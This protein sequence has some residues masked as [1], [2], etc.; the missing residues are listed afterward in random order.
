M[1]HADVVLELADRLLA[2]LHAGRELVVATVVGVDGSAPRTLGTSMAWD[3]ERVIGSIA[4]GCVEGAV[5]DVAD[6]VLDDG[7]TRVIEFGVP[8]DGAAGELALEA[9]LSCGGALTLHLA[10][11]RPADA[12]LAALERASAGGS[13]R[14][15]L[16]EA[17][18]AVDECD[19]LFVDERVPLARLIIVGAMEFSVAL[20]AAAQPLGYA[21]TV[22]DP[23]AVFMTPERFPGAE[24][25]VQWPTEFMRGTELDERSVVCLLSHDDRF[26]AETLLLA[27]RS[28][29]R[30]VGA[31]GS[32][33]TDARRRAR[34]AELGARS[35]ELTRLHSPIGLDLG[36][37]TPEETAV[38][39]LAEVLQERAAASARPLADLDGAIHAR[40]AR[41]ARPA[42]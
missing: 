8:D 12:A 11:L 37:S 3:G 27:L 24:L 15:R 17:G 28:P 25:V 30:Y 1:C 14:I 19:S 2:R 33:R 9:G 5:L 35:E 42:R 34:L 31:M 21:V 29:A 22:C 36:A 40:P 20:S 23:R 39:I 41:P 13:S 10:L 16:T 7:V 4:G 18:F 38:S 6:R 26:D 32:R